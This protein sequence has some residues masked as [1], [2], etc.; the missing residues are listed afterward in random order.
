MFGTDDAVF[1]APAGIRADALAAAYVQHVASRAVRSVLGSRAPR[2][3]ADAIGEDRT[4]SLR[5]LH[6]QLPA[7]LDDLAAWALLAGSSVLG[8]VTSD[9]RSLLPPEVRH[10]DDRWAPG[11]GRLPAVSYSGLPWRSV[12]DDIAGAIERDA[13]D[14]LLS[15]GAL[16]Y[17]AAAA[18]R[19]AGVASGGLF[20][21]EPD[22][23]LGPI[24]LSVGSRPEA[25]VEVVAL[26]GGS[27]AAERRAAVAALLAAV[28]RASIADAGVRHVVVSGGVSVGRRELTA[29]ESVGSSDAEAAG[30]ND[31]LGSWW[32]V[33]VAVVAEAGVGPETV[34][35][36]EVGK[37]R[38]V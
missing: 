19:R 21:D 4:T 15:R 18:L 26:R 5:K 25:V 24:A 23:P 2:V 28:A 17:L 22:T 33:P 36:V 20:A 7:R 11:Q 35:I 13:V 9:P 31:P 30:A 14:G 16:V 1:V 8:A 29:L 12:A 27:S 38:T 34:S 32:E 6:G 37:I 3:V 10:L